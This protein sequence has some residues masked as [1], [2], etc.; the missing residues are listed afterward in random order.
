M[1]EAIDGDQVVDFLNQHSLDVME[2]IVKCS[3]S[4]KQ[5]NWTFT[6]TFD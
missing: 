3:T 2:E 5:C 6:E 1:H 4:S